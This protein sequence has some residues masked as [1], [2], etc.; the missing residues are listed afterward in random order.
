M[1]SFFLLSIQ[2]LTNQLVLSIAIELLLHLVTFLW[3]VNI[4]EVAAPNRATQVMRNSDFGGTDHAREK[5][6]VL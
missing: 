4:A 1:A 3:R 6:F 2:T 5:G